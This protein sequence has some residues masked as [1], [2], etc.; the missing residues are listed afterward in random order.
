MRKLELSPYYPPR[1]RWYGP[2]FRIFDTVRRLTWLD[3]IHLPDRTSFAKFVAGLL[4]PGAAFWVRRERVIGAAV[5]GGYVLM[6]LVFV[7]WLGHAL[8]NIAFGLML[9]LHVSSILFLCNP[10]LAPA[11]LGFRLLFSVCVLVAVGGLLY[12]PARARVQE[13][14]L[15]PLSV[16]GQVV[17]VQTF[18]SPKRVQRG[19]W[20]AYTIQATSEAGVAV[21]EGYGLRPVLAV[22]GDRV[23]FTAS[24]CE[25][26]G[27]AFP[28]QAHMPSR[29]E[30]V[31]PEKHWF[32]WPN[33]AI[34]LHGNI[35]EA[36][37]DAALL[38][39]ALVDEEQFVGKPFQRWL[40]RH[41]SMQ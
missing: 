21:Q 9:S 12:A 3:R 8:G 20:I 26:N 23:R 7:L 38:R 41:Q 29:G 34:N 36:T 19:D 17:V 31:V 13:R 24:A 10:W 16:Q 5:F 35:S 14:W 15:I 25:V 1:A 11:R 2:L 30:L 18:T 37:A 28:R 40:W 22:A 32:L 27:V 33:L 39:L 4:V 6:A